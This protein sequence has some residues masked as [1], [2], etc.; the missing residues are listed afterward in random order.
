[1]RITHGRW[2]VDTE[3]NILNYSDGRTTRIFTFPPGGNL[4][5]SEALDWIAGSDRSAWLLD[6][7][8]RDLTWALADLFG[9]SQLFPPP[10]IWTRIKSSSAQPPGGILRHP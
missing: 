10:E 4:T 5:P 7:D 2:F 9:L 1:M 3:A 6:D 8:L